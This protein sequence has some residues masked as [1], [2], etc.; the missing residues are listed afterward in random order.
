MKVDMKKLESEAQKVVETGVAQK[1]TADSPVVTS[2]KRSSM[3]AKG[4]INAQQ[5]RQ[6][7][8]DRLGMGGRGLRTVQH[9]SQMKT[10]EQRD[11]GNIAQAKFHDE[12]ANT[13][14]NNNDVWDR[15]ENGTAS[16][17]DD[18]S[19]FNSTNSNN[20]AFNTITPISAGHTKS[21]S[22]A[23]RLGQ[24]TSTRT[25]SN[26]DNTKSVSSDKYFGHQANS[27]QG[28]SYSKPQSDTDRLK[29][30]SNRSAVSSSDLWDDHQLPRGGSNGTTSHQHQQSNGYSLD[31][32]GLQDQVADISDASKE[33]VTRLG[34]LAGAAL[35]NAMDKLRQY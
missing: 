26:T 12:T 35:S 17:K 2:E 33:A 24:T 32:G 22:S 34:S 31:V 18:G 16:N 9:A 3:S 27:G 8:M 13:N 23:D 4:S 30:L 25:S 1:V 14:N 15:Y 6:D 11:P 7:N 10:I 29:S 19:M 21:N 28:D 5:K 20:S